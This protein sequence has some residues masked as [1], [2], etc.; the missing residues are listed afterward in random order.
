MHSTVFFIV[1][2]IAMLVEGLALLV[3]LFQPGLRY[4]LTMA[5]PGE[6]TDEDFLRSLEVLTD[7]R[8]ERRNSIQVLTN[9]DHFYKAELEAIESAQR[10]INLEAYI[11]QRGEVSQKFLDAMTAKAA[12]GVCVKLLVDSVGSAGLRKSD[13]QALCAAGGKFVRFHPL[14]SK[15]FFAFN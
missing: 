5:P 9:G 2:V 14:F 7:S 8:I 15:Q 3:F 1:A 12:A 11:F 10:S 13:V 4:T 6:V